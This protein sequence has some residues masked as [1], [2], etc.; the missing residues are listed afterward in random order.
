LGFLWLLMLMLTLKALSVDI[1]NIIREAV[2][3]AGFNWR[4]YVLRAYFDTHLTQ[5][6]S[7]SLSCKSTDSSG[8]A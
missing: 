2:R 1:G 4:P 5:A 6:E 7:R 8:W 3:K